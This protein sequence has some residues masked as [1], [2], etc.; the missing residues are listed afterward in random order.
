MCSPSCNGCES[1]SFLNRLC[2]ESFWFFCFLLSVFH[3]FFGTGRYLC[4]QTCIESAVVSWALAPGFFMA[5]GSHNCQV[6]SA[7]GMTVVQ[8]TLGKVSQGNTWRGTWNP[9][10]RYL[11]PSHVCRTD[12][13]SKFHVQQ[14]N[15]KWS[16]NGHGGGISGGPKEI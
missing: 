16:T 12:H 3:V 8:L 5:P 1:A 15:C 4:F 13:F 7:T 11:W 9:K 6:G 2:C 14:F 10:K